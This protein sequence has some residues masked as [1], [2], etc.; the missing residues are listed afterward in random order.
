MIHTFSFTRN[1]YYMHFLNRVRNRASSTSYLYF[2]LKRREGT[3]TLWTP[4]TITY[5]KT[6]VRGK[7]LIPLL[8]G[9]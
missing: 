5:V 4:T 8:Q 2:H 7:N 6:N 3:Q 1:L 9:G